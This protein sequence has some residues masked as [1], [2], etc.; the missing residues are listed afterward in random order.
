MDGGGECRKRDDSAPCDMHCLGTA[1]YDMEMTWSGREE[2]N[3]TERPH[4]SRVVTPA[5]DSLSIFARRMRSWCLAQFERAH[6]GI[7]PLLLVSW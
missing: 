3:E 5:D 2:V 6:D 7:P 1:M 4:Q